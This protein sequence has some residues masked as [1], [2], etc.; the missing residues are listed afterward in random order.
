MKGHL[1]MK[2]EPEVNRN[3]AARPSRLNQLVVG[4]VLMTLPWVSQ[5]SMAATDTIIGGQVMETREVQC[6]GF[7]AGFGYYKNERRV[8]FRVRTHLSNEGCRSPFSGMYCPTTEGPIGLH[9]EIP[10][11]MPATLDSIHKVICS[12]DV[13]NSLSGNLQVE[14]QWTTPSDKK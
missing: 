5:F 7:K 9:L 8:V 1:E 11:S 10:Q 2:F 6:Q 3:I 12:T 14:Q 4:F 13:W